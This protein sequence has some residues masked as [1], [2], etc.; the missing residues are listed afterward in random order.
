MS[1][2]TGSGIDFEMIEDA[3]HSFNQM[4]LQPIVAQVVGQL[5]K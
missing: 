5:S 4:E 2:G 3:K 1:T